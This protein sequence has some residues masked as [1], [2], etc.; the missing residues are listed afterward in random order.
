MRDTTAFESSFTTWPWAL[1]VM[2]AALLLLV[3]V[4][5]ARRLRQRRA[6]VYRPDESP[7]NDYDLEAVSLEEV[8]TEE[9]DTRLTARLDLQASARLDAIERALIAQEVGVEIVGAVIARVEFPAEQISNL[10]DVVVS[11]IM[12]VLETLP[13]SSRNWAAAAT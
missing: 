11:E 5:I 1:F 3:V 10:A 13:D 6:P 8:L 7:S 9:L 12:T 4:R 2:A